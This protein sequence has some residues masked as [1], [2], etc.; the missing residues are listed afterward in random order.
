MRKKP[1]S[2]T[3][4]RPTPE[5]SAP[6][7][8]G[9]KALPGPQKALSPACTSAPPP[10][11]RR[12][13]VKP[14]NPTISACCLCLAACSSVPTSGTPTLPLPASLSQRCPPLPDFGGDDLGALLR[15]T[16]EV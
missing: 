6:N 4:P 13:S 2:S 10:A 3:R 8:P 16:R 7:R 5:P 15:Y 14:R 9:G 12:P 11:S 1:P